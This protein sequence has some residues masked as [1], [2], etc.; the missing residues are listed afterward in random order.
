MNKPLWRF[1]GFYSYPRAVNK[2]LSWQLIDLLCLRSHLPLLMGGDWN[3]IVDSSEK[4]GGSQRAP[5]MMQNFAY[6]LRYKWT[7]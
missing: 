2:H 5:F 3:E 4:W 7:F 6:T 1:I